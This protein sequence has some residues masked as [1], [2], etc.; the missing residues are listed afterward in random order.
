MNS[1]ERVTKVL[2]GELPDRVPV[3]LHCYLTACRMS[4]GRFDE[5]L[6][7]GELLAESQLKAWRTFGHDVIML[8]NGVTAEAEALGAAIRY[9]PDGPPHVAEPLIKKP[10]DIEKLR[11]PDPER[12][13]P[14]N[15]LLKAT[16]IVKRETG[17]QVF[18]NGRSD[19]GPIALALALVGPDRFLTMLMEPERKNWCHRFL[20]LCSRMNV[21]LCQAQVRSGAH[22]SSIGLAGASLISPALFDAFELPRARAFCAALHQAGGFAFVHACGD[23]T[24]LLDHLLA[25]GADCLELDP[26][27]DPETC[28]R[29]VQGRATVLGMIDPTQVMRFGTP[30]TIRDHARRILSVMAPGGGFL[31]GPGCALPADTPVENVLALVECNR[32]EGVY[33]ADG[34]LAS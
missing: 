10:D 28:K 1:L 26:G 8:E 4:G 34:R 7:S 23:E 17:G 33:A 16:R 32:R 3:A 29:A 31:L 21:A 22:S 30:D 9:T 24:L 11:V 5:I 20:D 25:T 27:T 13:F 12:T 19:Q 15:E 14:L 2:Q 6:R 18:I